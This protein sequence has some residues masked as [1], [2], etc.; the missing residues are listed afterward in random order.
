MYEWVYIYIDMAPN[1]IRPG[2]V[3]GESLMECKEELPNANALQKW[4][5]K[6]GWGRRCRC[7]EA[8]GHSSA[9]HLC[10]V[11][12]TPSLISFWQYRATHSRPA[13]SLIQIQLPLLHTPPHMW[14][15]PC[16]ASNFHRYISPLDLNPIWRTHIKIP[17]HPPSTCIIPSGSFISPLP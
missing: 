14:K 9:I 3:V 1:N 15:M 8:R 4:K 6:I 16:F 2:R 7:M 10:Y 12:P 11:A 13:F 5:I 17:P